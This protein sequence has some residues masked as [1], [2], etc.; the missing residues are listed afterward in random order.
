MALDPC[1]ERTVCLG[2]AF[3]KSDFLE[4]IFLIWIN[5]NNMPGEVILIGQ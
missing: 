1:F 4:A 3:G 5:L 2:F